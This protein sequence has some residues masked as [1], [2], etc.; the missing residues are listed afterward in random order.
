MN[1]ENIEMKVFFGNGCHPSV[2]E[3]R[4]IIEQQIDDDG[5]W[6][7][8]SDYRNKLEEKPDLEEEEEDCVLEYAYKLMLKKEKEKRHK[9]QENLEEL[10]PV[11]T[12]PCIVCEYV[13]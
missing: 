8:D 7:Y 4:R 6:C 2:E 12:T 1:I 13:I 3:I 5:G 11:G 10:M 9:L